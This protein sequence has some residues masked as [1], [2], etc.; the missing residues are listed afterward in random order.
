MTWRPRRCSPPRA[1]KSWWRR[2]RRPRRRPGCWPAAPIWCALSAGPEASR[3]CSSISPGSPSSPPS[4]S[5]AGRSASAPCHVHAA[6]VGPAGP[7][8]R[9]VSQPRRGAGRLGADPQRRHHRRQHRQ[10][11]ALRRRGDGAHG[12]RRRGDHGRRRRRRPA[13]V[14]SARCCSA[15]TARASARRG[16]HR[17][18]LPG[19]RGRA[20]LGVRQD[21]LPNGGERRAAQ[22]GARRP[23]RRGLRHHRRRARSARRGGRDRLPRAVLEQALEGR[24]GGRGDRARLF[25]E[26]CV[27][28]VQESIPGRY[29]CPTSSTPPWVSPTTPG[30]CWR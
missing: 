22:R 11:V 30:T 3:T 8:A 28:A 27:A 6:A 20:P 14:P 5:T 4:A 21:R 17:V 2:W 26:G 9:A 10:R 15:R 24:A 13:H 12:T 1:W 19:A 29:S 23:L 7:R 25:A 18:L 16:D